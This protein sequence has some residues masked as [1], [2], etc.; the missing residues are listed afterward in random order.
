MSTFDVSHAGFDPN[1]RMVETSDPVHADLMNAMFG[2]LIRND[3]AIMEAA[4]GLFATKNGQAAFLLNLHKDGLKYGVHFED[5]DVSPSSVGTRLYDAAGLVAYPSTDTVRA[6]NDF[7]GRSV[8]YHL[9]VNGYVDTD[10]EFQVTKIRGIDDDF[11]LTDADVWCLFLTQWISITISAQGET[12]VLSDTR[13]DGSFPEG[14]AIRTDGTIR[15]FV[16][17]AKY[18]DSATS[19]S[20]PNSVSGAS[21]SYN[22]S[23][24]SLITKTRLK[25]TQY[26]ATSFQDLER[27]NNLFDVAFATR[28]SQSVMA[29]A[30][31][32]YLQYPAT[33]VETG[34]EHIVISKANAANLVV[35]SCVSIGNATALNSAGTAGNTDRG[36]AGMHAKA[37]RVK[38]VSIEDY[39][40]TNSIVT[41][42]NGGVTF[43]TASTTVSGVECPT[44]ITVMPWHTGSTDSVLGSCGSPNHN[45]DSKNPYLLFGVEYALGQY[46]VCGNAKMDIVNGVMTPW[47]CYDAPDISTGAPSSDYTKVGYDV[48]LTDNAWEYISELGFD[49]DNPMARYGTKVEATSST[50]YADAQHTGTVDE[51]TNTQR[52]ILL[53]GF[54]NVGAGTGRRCASLLYTLGAAL[55]PFGARLSATGRCAQAAA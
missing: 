9:D 35:G 31:S 28:N 42:D 36:Q 2:Q 3:V 54:L 1:L 11:S 39:D 27:M 46:E 18:Q 7:E 26:C 38:I 47:V 53:L 51:T 33:V 12:K 20:A 10:G 34:V 55:W 37:D 17:I 5:F 14:G 52:E 29:G 19:G 50:G 4:S 49:A 22:N 48:A 40:G 6:Q 32:Y 25:G 13:F 45:T 24:N 30:V 23:H 21:P 15:P 43:S 8:F 16:A 41:V 44:Y